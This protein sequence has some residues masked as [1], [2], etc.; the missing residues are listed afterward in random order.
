M[1]KKVFNYLSQNNVVQA[2]RHIIG[3]S[4]SPICKVEHTTMTTFDNRSLP[5]HI[6]YCFHLLS[7]DCSSQRKF[8]VLTRTMKPGLCP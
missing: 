5:F 4:V 3:N 6:D 2:A 1:A 7:G 8:A